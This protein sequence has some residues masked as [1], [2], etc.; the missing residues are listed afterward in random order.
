MENMTRDSLRA[1]G[2]TDEKMLD[3][4]LAMR[5]NEITEANKK[6]VQMRKDLEEATKK[7]K[8]V[9]DLTS[10]IKA[11]EAQNMT[12]EELQAQKIKEAENAQRKYEKLSNKIEAQKIL[13]SGGPTSGDTMEKILD[14]ICSENQE[15]T[16]EAANI[17]VEM[18]KSTREN[19]EKK[20]KEEL[21]KNNPKPD[22][23]NMQVGDDV[24]TKEK[25]DNL[26]YEEMAAYAQK[27][28]EGFAQM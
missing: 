21:L 27:D 8:S 24:M 5:S 28:P 15:A 22:A 17:I 11:L 18:V 23:T 7:A 26:S 12:A 10:K 3:G 2:I 25:F 13:L 4:I 16:L 9:D 19:T 1:L 20:V 6:E 14:K